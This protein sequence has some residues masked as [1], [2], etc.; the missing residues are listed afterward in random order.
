MRKGDQGRSKGIRKWFRNTRIAS[1]A[2]ALQAG[3]ARNNAF[4]SRLLF[5]FPHMDEFFLSK[6]Y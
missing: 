2:Y 3:V 1:N 4:P 6:H 5:L